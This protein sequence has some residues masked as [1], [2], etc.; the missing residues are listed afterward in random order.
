MKFKQVFII[1]S[2]LIKDMG[3]GKIAG[4][5]AHGESFYMSH[6]L[7][8][9]AVRGDIDSYYKWRYEDNELMTK[10]VKKANEKEMNIIYELLNG[11]IWVHKVIDRGI[12]QIEAN[13]LTCIVVEPLPEERCVKLFGHLKLL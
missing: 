2:D 3:I 9:Y 13:S 1:N 8:V 5:V 12:T 10:I 6:I 7:D 11:N 4:Q